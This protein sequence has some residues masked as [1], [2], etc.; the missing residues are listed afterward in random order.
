MN[1]YHCMIELKDPED[2]LGFA[3]AAE[4]WF[5]YLRK[6]DLVQ[7]WRLL[8]R[9]FG[10]AS[11]DHTDFIAELEVKDMATLEST[12]GRLSTVED[13]EE[14]LYREMHD[15]IAVAKIGFYRDYPDPIKRERIALV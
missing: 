13:D 3:A 9:K 15:M 4:K 2:A 8:R 1:I 5:A 12:F 11:S 14:Q 6:K 7:G 10:L